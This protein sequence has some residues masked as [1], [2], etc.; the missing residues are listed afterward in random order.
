MGSRT[1]GTLPCSLFFRYGTLTCERV[2]WREFVG[3]FVLCNYCKIS[4][5][6]NDAELLANDERY[7]LLNLDQCFTRESPMNGI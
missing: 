1:S 4:C 6:C 7:R 2:W 3:L 5:D